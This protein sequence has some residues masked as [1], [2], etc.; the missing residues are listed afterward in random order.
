MT[1][2]RQIACNCIYWTLGTP[3]FDLSLFVWYR[4]IKQKDNN[5]W[6]VRLPFVIQRKNY[7][8][9]SLMFMTL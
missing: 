6:E 1:S 2:K 8:L 5:T 7:V 9:L 4:S 3:S